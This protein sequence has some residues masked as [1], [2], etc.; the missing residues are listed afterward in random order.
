MSAT[1]F[2][3][4]SGDCVQGFTLTDLVVMLAAL[5]VLAAIV[6]ARVASGKEEAGLA[7][8]TSNLH[9]VT[10][11]VLT[12]CDD[13]DQTLPGPDDSAPNNLWWWYKEQVKDYLGLTEPSS[14]NDL[15]FACPGDRGYS[16]PT[17][18]HL[19]S[20]FDF[21]SY[22]FNGVTLP[23]IPNI[24]GWELSA[25][26]RPRQTLLVMEWTAH[27]PLAWHKSKTGKNNMPFYC[28]AQNVVGFVD[29]HVSFSKIYYDGYNAAYTRD[30]IPGYEYQYS[31]N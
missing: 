18:F 15:V 5:S 4:A 11:A 19:N 22:V 17:P 25:V 13:N 30:P 21:G 8:C 9:Q 16:D 26:K 24:A 6:L 27:A 12:F 29:G 20:R 7:R 2:S 28:D 23:G 14:A 10:H 1:P 31:G 3:P